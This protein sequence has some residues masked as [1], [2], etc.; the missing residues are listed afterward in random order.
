M[1]YCLQCYCNTYYY[2]HMFIGSITVPFSQNIALQ[3]SRERNVVHVLVWL[4]HLIDNTLKWAWSISMY[5]F[6]LA[7]SLY[8]VNIP[9]SV[10]NPS[11]LSIHVLLLITQLPFGIPSWRCFMVDQIWYSKFWNACDTS[12]E[13]ISR[14]VWYG[15]VITMEMTQN[16]RQEIITLYNEGYS[17]TKILRDI[18]VS[19]NTVAL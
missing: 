19:Y 14:L 1:Y 7:P 12:S 17:K 18:G 13:L 15:H 4:I 3:K 8:M 10:F 9:R 2:F 11:Y 16:T 6:L 5:S